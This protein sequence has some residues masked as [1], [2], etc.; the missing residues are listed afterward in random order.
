MKKLIYLLC[1]FLLVSCSTTKN[2]EPQETVAIT[3]SEPTEDTSIDYTPYDVKLIH[4]PMECVSIPVHKLSKNLYYSTGESDSKYYRLVA[5]YD[6]NDF[7]INERYYYVP[8]GIFNYTQ[9]EIENSEYTTLAVTNL[10]DLTYDTYKDDI[11]HTTS[12]TCHIDYEND[13]WEPATEE[14]EFEY[15]QGKKWFNYLIASMVFSFKFDEADEYIALSQALDND[16]E[17][18]KA[19]INEIIK[20]YGGQI[21]TQ[22]SIFGM[23]TLVI[24]A[25]HNYITML[26]I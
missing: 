25:E 11:L 16:K 4:D 9:E 6:F 20:Y 12:A 24:E 10:K 8:S 5:L 2:I 14:C 7:T 26:K 21:M 23:E 17:L 22:R 1:M 19:Y 18:L 15:S 13:T 3:T